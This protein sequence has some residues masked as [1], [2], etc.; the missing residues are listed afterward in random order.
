VNKKGN[1]FL[2]NR[3]FVLC[4]GGEGGGGGQAEP[5]NARNRAMQNYRN[6]TPTRPRGGPDF[7]WRQ[8]MIDAVQLFNVQSEQ[9]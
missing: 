1:V 3:N 6:F 7:T 4:R 5:K 8:R 2:V 9:L